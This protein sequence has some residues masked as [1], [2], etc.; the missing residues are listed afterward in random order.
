[1]DLLGESLGHQFN[2]HTAREVQWLGRMGM[3]EVTVVLIVAEVIMAEGAIMAVEDII[4]TMGVEDE[5]KDITVEVSVTD[6]TLG[7]LE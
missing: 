2:H 4:A 6:H 3:D 5:E 1:M 7:L